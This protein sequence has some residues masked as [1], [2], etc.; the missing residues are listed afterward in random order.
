MRTDFFNQQVERLKL[1]F[2]PKAFDPESTRL[3]GREVA[4]LDEETFM[5]I[6]DFL[7]TSR[8]HTKPPLLSDFR[9]A[10]LRSEKQR[11]ERDV[12]GAL[13]AMERDASQWS[14]DGLQKYLKQHYPGCRTLVD[15]VN[16]ERLKIQVKKAK[17]EPWP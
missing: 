12:D 1:R 5:R 10:R 6:I 4:S 15:A 16:V 3:I 13:R 8:T 11:L 2:S 14:T 9:D 17:G 7:I